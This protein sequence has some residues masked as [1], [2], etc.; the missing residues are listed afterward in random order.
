MRKFRE[1]IAKTLEPEGKPTLISII[2]HIIMGIII[3]LGCAAVVVDV[4]FNFPHLT[5]YIHTFE[6]ITVCFISTECL[7]KLW[8][9]DIIYPELGPVRCRVEYL[10]SFDFF[11]DLVCISAIFLNNVPSAFGTIKFVKL[12]KLVRLIKLNDIHDGEED[13]LPGGRPLTRLERV[14]KRVYEIMCENKKGDVAAKIYDVFAVI[15]ILLSVS[16]ILVETFVQENSTGYTVLFT[17]EVIF[18]CFF[19]LEYIL[20]VWT[21]GYEYPHLDSDHA[22]MKYIFS[23]MSLIDLLSILPFFLMALPGQE[24]LQ[25]GSAVAI[26]KIFKI[27]RITRVLKFSRYIS[28]FSLFG[29]AVKKKAKQIGFAMVIIAFL[30]CTWSVLLYSFES[31]NNPEIF[32]NGFSG[33]VYACQILAGGTDMF[34]LSTMEQLTPMGNVMVVAMLLSGGCLIGVPL[35]IIS[36]EFGKMVEMSHKEEHQDV[37][38]DLVEHLTLEDKKEITAKY[39]PKVL[40][41]QQKE[42]SAAPAPGDPSHDK[43]E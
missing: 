18:T 15:L 43:D 42:Q 1:A 19:V 35:G 13:H 16:T 14:Q 24:P 40:K 6:L 23:F 2:Y 7:L 26:V 11:I 27:L 10:T 12:L 28:T 8:V 39:L 36:G 21:A 32:R 29:I 17:L 41:M 34:D 4:W 37:F 31:Q 5:P 25:L 22:K 38:A 33:I 9:A 20:R 30:I 3:V